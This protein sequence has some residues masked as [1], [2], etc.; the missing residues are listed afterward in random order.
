GELLGLPRGLWW[1]GLFWLAGA[2]CAHVAGYMIQQP[3]VS[4][5][6]MLAGVYFVVGLVYGRAWLRAVFFP[7]VLLG[8]CIPVS[9]LIQSIS[10]PLRLL[11]T[12][13]TAGISQDVLGI[14][15][16]REGTKL[17]DANGTYQYDVDV[18]CSGI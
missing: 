9:S 1:P 15:L 13:I 14:H 16:V 12:Q 4:A 2:L 6:A 8:F 3:R 10:F 18:A 7:F 11:A 5:V 17:L